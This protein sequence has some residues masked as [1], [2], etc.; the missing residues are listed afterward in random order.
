MQLQYIAKILLRLYIYNINLQHTTCKD[1]LSRIECDHT[2]LWQNSI[3]LS[4]FMRMLQH[5]NSVASHP[6][7]PTLHPYKIYVTCSVT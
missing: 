1:A 2:T 6:A 4:Q 7:V 5:G 3:A